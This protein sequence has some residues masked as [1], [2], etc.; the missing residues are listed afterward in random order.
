LKILEGHGKFLG[1]SVGTLMMTTV[2]L[3]ITMINCECDDK[4][5]IDDDDDDGDAGCRGRVTATS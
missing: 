1:K 3:I 2:T 4:D 5:E